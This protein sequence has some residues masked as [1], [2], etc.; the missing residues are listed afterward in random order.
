MLPNLL[1]AGDNGLSPPRVLHLRQI[2][3]RC[4]RRKRPFHLSLNG[5][6]QWEAL[7]LYQA[8]Y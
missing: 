6:A 7:Y 5:L 3:T 2:G 8:L 4:Q 1:V